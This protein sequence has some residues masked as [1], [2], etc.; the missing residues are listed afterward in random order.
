MPIKQD[1]VTKEIIFTPPNRGDLFA[2]TGV[3]NNGNFAI[4][5]RSDYIKQIKFDPASQTTNTTVTITSGASITDVV[6]TLPTSS[7]TFSTAAFKTFQT[8]SGTAPVAIAPSDTLTFATSTLSITGN[9]STDT[10]TFDVLSV[11]ASA[12]PNPSSSTLGGVNSKAAV[13]HNFLTGIGT[14]GS[15]SAAQP[16]TADVAEGSNLYY[17]NARGIGSTLTGYAL[18]QANSGDTLSTDTLLQAI[19]RLSLARHPEWGS[20][21]WDDFDTQVTT[22]SYS[23]FQSVT[24][25][26]GASPAPTSSGVDTGHYG[27]WTLAT[28]TAATNALSA[29]RRN[30]QA[31]IPGASTLD[32]KYLHQVVTLSTSSDEC[33]YRAGYGTSVAQGTDHTNGIYFEYNRALTF[34]VTGTTVNGQAG[35]TGLTGWTG[36]IDGTS[37]QV[38]MAITGTG[39][40]ASTTISVAPGAGNTLTLSKTA[41]AGGAVTLTITVGDFWIFK[42]ANNGSRSTQVTASPVQV[43]TWITHRFTLDN[44]GTTATGYVNG[45]SVATITTNIPSGTTPTP[46][47]DMV[48]TLYK[49]AGTGASR[50]VLIDYYWQR[51]VFGGAR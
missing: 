24:A 47:S 18:S 50:T 29:L 17:T 34:T 28:T 19:E 20:E 46:N 39:I 16:T 5:D 36:V 41:S 14:D 3:A 44:G 25:N 9:S 48:F 7:G 33:V 15:V 38:G 6:L 1:P 43:A 23:S 2:L 37:V 31:Y 8:P 22:E 10:I 26:S 45:S 32:A 12:L 11:P 27:V 13:T 4:C 21:F 49:T 30:T 51:I 40:Q 42:T 35:V